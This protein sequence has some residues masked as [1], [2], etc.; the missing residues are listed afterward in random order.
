MAVGT[1]CDDVLE[2]PE[3]ASHVVE[4][5]IE[6]H[7]DT[8][9]VE[10]VHDG[11]EII[12]RAQASVHARVVACVV[13]VGIAL[14]DGIE[15]HAGGTEPRDVLDPSVVHEPEQAV[16]VVIGRP[17][18]RAIVGPGGA[19]QPQRIDLIDEGT[20]VP[21]HVVSPFL[22][23]GVLCLADALGNATRETYLAKLAVRGVKGGP[24]LAEQAKLPAD[25]QHRADAHTRVSALHARD[26]VT[27]HP[28]RLGELVGREAT[29]GPP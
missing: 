5:T 24:H 19:T 29:H 15:H 12:V 10:G 16:I 4:H 9:L 6:H 3:A 1:L 23:Q 13:A 20:L 18:R 11:L 14:E 27:R 2:C 28:H 22:W 8:R 17:L 25:V 7:T 26:G 21:V